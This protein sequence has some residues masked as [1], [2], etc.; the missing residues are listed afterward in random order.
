MGN[1]YLSMYSKIQ[2]FLLV[3]TIKKKTQEMSVSWACVGAHGG[4]IISP[5]IVVLIT[6]VTLLWLL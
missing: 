5:L 1:I 4:V 2:E 6:V 3:E